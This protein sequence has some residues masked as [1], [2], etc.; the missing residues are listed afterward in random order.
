[1]RCLLNETIA[2]SAFSHEAP[3]YYCLVLR[4]IL[5]I[6]FPVAYELRPAKISHFTFHI[7]LDCFVRLH[8]SETS[9]YSYNNLPH[10]VHTI[11]PRLYS[12]PEITPP[13]NVAVG[14]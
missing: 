14:K 7:T 12:L 4:T 2:C 13:Y 1:M 6:T 9:L 3:A 8:A 10:P 5:R 11:R